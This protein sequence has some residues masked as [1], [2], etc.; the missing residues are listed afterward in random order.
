MSTGS[1]I[2]GFPFESHYATIDGVK[3]H[4]VDE[5]EGPPILMFHGQ[6]TWS[7]LYRKMIPPLVEAGFRC[8]APDLMGFGMS[9]KPNAE[10]AYTLRRHVELMAGLVE[11][12][13]LE[14][15]TIVGQ[16]W[17]GPIGLR[18]AIDHQGNVRA[19]VILNTLIDIQK[20]PMFFKALFRSGGFSSFL[21]RRL[22]VFRKMA[23]SAGFKRPMP[24]EVKAMYKMPHPNASVRGGIA[25]FPKMIPANEHH[26]N[27]S[28]I[29]EISQ[30]LKKWDIPVLVCFS[31]KD[32][33]FK[34]D[35]GRA[36]A[37]MVPNGRFHL[38][39]GAGHY[40]QEDAG[41]EIVEHMI[42]FLRDEA[43][44]IAA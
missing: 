28:Y 21:S 33:V 26:E 9:D 44:L 24:K 31:D 35:A 36:I 42:P 22:D 38:I 30:T 10:S 4:Y 34:P 3:L 40:L 43:K 41:E 18:Y 37:E 5:G 20:M 27:A 2:P 16:D 25:A 29:S 11:N 15:V 39:E 6:P 12:L 8:V 32:I 13:K 1:S 7:Y 19:L 23:F 17:G 14:G